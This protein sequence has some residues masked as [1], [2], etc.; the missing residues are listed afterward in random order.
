MQQQVHLRQQEGQGLGL[1]GV[2]A[3]LLQDAAL[4]DGIGLLF[5]VAVG[6][7]QEAAGAAGRVQHRFADLRV[8]DAH[9]E[10]HHRARGV[11]LARIAGGVAQSRSRVSYRRLRVWISS[12][13]SKWMA[14]TRLTTSRSR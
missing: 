12:D 6:F 14:S 3:A 9:H 7:D 2:D 5:Q 10:L 1:A 8:D 4:F 11:Y 13:E